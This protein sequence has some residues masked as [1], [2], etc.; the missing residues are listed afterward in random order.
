MKKAKVFLSLF[1]LLFLLTF[2]LKTNLVL[3][4]ESYWDG[5]IG[6]DRIGMVYGEDSSSTGDIRQQAV[7]IINVVL[8]ILGILLLVLIM[9]AG[10]QWMT[11]GGNE[12]QVKKAKTTLKNAI[13]GL[14]IVL[15]SWSITRFMLNYFECIRKSEINNI[16]VDQCYFIAF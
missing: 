7:K 9:Y 15:L 13:I 16:S 1:L 8:T 6:M 11:A 4:Q 14:V 3:A 12:D 10:F 2:L 5:Q